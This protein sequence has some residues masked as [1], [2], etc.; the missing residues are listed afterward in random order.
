MPRTSGVIAGSR[1]AAF[2]SHEW[3]AGRTSESLRRAITLEV[4]LREATLERG[5]RLRA[6]ANLLNTGAG[7]AVPSGDPAHRIEVRFELED[8]TG[9]A[10]KGAAPKSHWL[11]RE[12]ESLPPFAQKSDTRLAAASS[13][14]F[15]YSIVIPR[16]LQAG[17]FTLKV[18]V[19]WWAVSPDRAR[20]AGLDE[21]DV[22]VQVTQQRI[23][24]SV[25]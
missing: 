23:P 14:V 16:K 15:D 17:T 21:S 11:F 2:A 8:P 25:F 9:A 1:Y 7:H 24:F 4:L 5:H 19:N 13:R 20:T 22:L 12:V 6:T 18:T 10:V 3:L